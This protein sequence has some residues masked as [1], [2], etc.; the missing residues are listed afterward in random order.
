MENQQQ[1]K[2]GMTL[3]KKLI[4]LILPLIVVSLSIACIVFYLIAKQTIQDRASEYM[5]QYL[6]QLST[7]IDNELD[8]S[9]RMNAQLAVNEQVVD[10]L[11][12]YE[13][14]DNLNKIERRET[15]TDIFV[16]LISV[17]DNIKDIYVF[18]DHGNE[19]YAKKP[20]GQNFAEM[21]QMNWYHETLEKN[22]EYVIFLDEKSG[23][24][25]RNP[26]M[27]IGIARSVVDIY[28]KTTYGV[29]LIEIPYSI[30]E[31]CVLGEKRQLNLEQGNI[32]I[33]NVDGSLL[34]TTFSSDSS[35]NGMEKRIETANEP[36][37]QIEKVD[38]E[39]AIRINCTSEKS[40]WRYTYL[41]K[42]KY[43]MQ[44]MEKIKQILVVFVVCITVV[45]G[46][47][48]VLF[49]ELFLRPVKNL[50]A[51]MQKVT[52]GDYEVQVQANTQDEF[53]Y[54]IKTFN[55]M[56]VS[57]RQLIKKVYQAE[58]VQKEAQLEAL[59]QQIN[60]HFLYNTL[61]SMR[62]LALEENCVKVADMAKNI[63]CFMRYNMRTEN[64]WTILKEEKGHV[65]NY[66]RIINYRFDNKI[67]L[68]T[69]LSEEMLELSVP[70][71][72]LQPVVENSVLHGL[73]EKK[74]DCEIVITGHIVESD[75]I[76]EISDNGTGILESA[77]IQI[78]ENLKKA[79]E[80]GQKQSRKESIGIYN[81]NSRLKLNY[82]NQYGVSL[83]SKKGNGTV[84]RL[85]FP[86]SKNQMGGEN[87]GSYC[88]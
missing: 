12:N 25:S 1:N 7:S 24:D 8:T 51:G 60:P 40:D 35:W 56:T 20:Y 80:V 79:V 71:F 29:V 67:S 53:H 78:N 27:A 81:V 85:T 6:V 73:S 33:Q 50:V 11:K 32:F 13:L 34:Y 62:G 49:S 30:L 87:E 23:A 48:T 28:T 21:S 14:A 63:S 72:I 31:D 83:K 84:V 18:D 5:L 17:Y 44:D 43:L 77:L 69:E 9:I 54:L 46:F 66:I 36:Q 26:D 74:T 10:T 86:V 47:I 4:M 16:S 3:K 37:M 19:F 55:N 45:A 61:E 52:E 42:M 65:T 76:I 75:A 64:N 22:G 39:D 88:R 38:G 59:Q 70:K 58:L 68:K 41:C 15:M 82:G 57:I 2:V